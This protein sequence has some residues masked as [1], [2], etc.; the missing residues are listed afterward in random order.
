M[1]KLLK[2]ITVTCI[3]LGFNV[4]I[5]AKPAAYQYSGFGGGLPSS[6]IELT[7]DEETDLDSI[8]TDLEAPAAPEKEPWSPT[9]KA[10]VITAS[11]VGGILVIGGTVAG[12][13]FLKQTMTECCEGL[14]SSCSESCSKGLSD[15]ISQSCQNKSIL[16]SPASALAIPIYVP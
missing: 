13:I 15:S 14:G 6:A 16:L 8:N 2:T 3:L 5:F 1:N 10:L 12:V 4:C 7:A 11:V 9:K